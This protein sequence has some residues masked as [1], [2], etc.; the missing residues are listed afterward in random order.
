MKIGTSLI[1]QETGQELQHWPNV[2]ATIIYKGETRTG[3][4]VGAQVGGDALLVDRVL[5]VSPPAGDPP[6]LSEAAVFNGGVVVVSRQ[7]GPV[8]LA[9]LKVA[10][11]ARVSAAAESARY[12]YVTPGSA[13]AM[14]YQE[15]SKEAKTYVIRVLSGADPLTDNGQPIAYP[16]LQARVAS[17]RYPNLAAAVAGTVAISVNWALIGAAIDEME[18]RAKLQIDAAQTVQ[19]IDAAATVVFP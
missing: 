6:V 8:D 13:K 7:Y 5:D 9:P 18:D 14:S 2:P 16:F 19:Q 1:L 11:K 17:G 12:K 4:I 10:A 3:A 15:V